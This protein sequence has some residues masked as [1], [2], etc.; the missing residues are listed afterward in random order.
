MGGMSDELTESDLDMLERFHAERA[1]NP[2]LAP[3]VG[4]G[5][6]LERFIAG[7]VVTHRQFITDQSKWVARNILP[8]QMRRL[9]WML[10]V[11]RSKHE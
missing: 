10:E 4:P 5:E 6:S 3:Y 8:M 2:D 11:S 9:R 1:N 7:E